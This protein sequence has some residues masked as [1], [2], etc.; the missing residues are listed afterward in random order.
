MFDTFGKI[1]LRSKIN[2]ENLK[3]QK[4]FLPWDK[5]ERIALILEK[6]DALNKSMVDKFIDETK[7]YIEVF[8]IEIASKHASYSDWH[9]FSKKDKSLWN[10]PKKNLESELKNKKYDAV[11]NTCTE[12]NLFALSVSASLPAYLKCSENNRFNL[13]DLI[14]KK[15]EPFNL[16]NYLDETVKYLKMIK[17]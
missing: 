4:K 2:D 11:I 14:I 7:K 5:I 12:A 15:T 3:R 1:I 10:L 13:A 16:K 9:C 17:A 8:Y 6:D